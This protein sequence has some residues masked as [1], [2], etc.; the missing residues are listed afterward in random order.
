[1]S[2]LILTTFRTMLK[3]WFLSNNAVLCFITTKSTTPKFNNP[4]LHQFPISPRRFC[5]ITATSESNT[6]PFSVSYLINNFGFSHE[7]ALKAFNNKQVRFNTPDNADSVITFFQN[8]GFPN[9][10]I[11]III[12]KAPWLLSSQPH[13]R[14]LPKFQFFLSN[15]ASLS[16]IVPLL[17]TNPRI[18]RSSL[19]KQIIPLF[20]LLSRCLKTN[21]DA[22][23]CLIKHW[24]TFTIY[25]HLIVANINLMT[26][27][28]IPH[29]V[30]AR[31]IRSRPFLICS[32]DLINSLEEIKGLGFDPSTTTFGYALLANNCT[33]K[34]L[35]DEKVDV[36]KKWGWSDEDVI[37]AFRCHPD[38][39]LTSI[40]KINL[41]MSFWV[42]QLGWDSL[43]LTKR[44]HILTHSL[45][46]WIVPR[47]LV[48]QFLLMKGLRKKNASL[49]TPFRYSEKL[50]LE[51]FVFSFKEE[52]DYLLKIYEEKIKL[53]YTMENNGMPFPN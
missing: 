32:K 39:M 51:K 52:S 40:E 48:V 27:F 29:S 8:H 45:E 20:Q 49:V 5:T 24:T 21:R 2:H 37:R 17:T 35:W 41:V 44:P 6:H 25:Y 18:L 26:D 38:M 22:I 12:Q 4:L 11:R 47:G 34:K 19:E 31:L 7:S 36:L 30:I 15:G 50:F 28:G 9:S 33:S 1:M 46:K 53:A 13:K 23:I 10:N 14:L 3:K 43:A 42:N 16:D